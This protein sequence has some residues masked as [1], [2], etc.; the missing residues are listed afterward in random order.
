MLVHDC[1]RR[2]IIGLIWLDLV[3][4]IYVSEKLVRVLAERELAG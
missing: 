2:S 1:D 3:R 4:K